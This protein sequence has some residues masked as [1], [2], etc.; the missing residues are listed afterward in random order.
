MTFSSPVHLASADDRTKLVNTVVGI[1]D[2]SWTTYEGY[3]SPL[4]IGW[5][6]AGCGSYG[7]DDAPGTGALQSCYERFLRVRCTIQKYTVCIYLTGRGNAQGLAAHRKRLV[8]DRVLAAVCARSA[9]SA[10]TTA[11]RVHPN[12]RTLV[13]QVGSTMATNSGITS[14]TH[15]QITTLKT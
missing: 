1:L 8:L 11:C 2:Q 3:T 13:T 14:W 10:T 15:V 9:G 7:G 5:M 4:G 6:C 12:S